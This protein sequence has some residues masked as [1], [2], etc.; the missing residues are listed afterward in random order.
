MHGEPWSQLRSDSDT[1]NLLRLLSIKWVTHFAMGSHN[2]KGHTIKADLL[3]SKCN[4]NRVPMRVLIKMVFHLGNHH[5]R[6]PVTSV[7]I[8]TTTSSSSKAEATT[9][10]S[11]KATQVT[12]DSMQATMHLLI[13]D[14][15]DSNKLHNSRGLT[16][17]T[18]TIRALTTN[19]RDLE[20][21]E[22][23]RLVRVPML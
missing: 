19:S 1:R 11:I 14:T 17:A 13:T 16:F 2:N 9:T 4:T 21:A 8:T 6:R 15:R 3:G 12:E 10:S 22:D 7:E 23:N 18:L 20:W 5:R